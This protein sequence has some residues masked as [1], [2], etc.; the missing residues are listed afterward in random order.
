MS[1]YGYSRDGRHRI[2]NALIEGSIVWNTYITDYWQYTRE[3]YDNMSF[4]GYV[5]YNMCQSNSFLC[6]TV[7]VA[8][9][10]KIPEWEIKDECFVSSCYI[11][12]NEFYITSSFSDEIDIYSAYIGNVRNGFQFYWQPDII[13]MQNIPPQRKY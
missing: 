11:Y 1:G 6:R 8:N 13:T 7:R 3:Y 12:N 9:P 5:S 10:W 2:R 4:N